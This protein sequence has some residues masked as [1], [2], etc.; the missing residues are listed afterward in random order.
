MNENNTKFALGFPYLR[1]LSPVTGE[2]LII[3]N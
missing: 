2:T 1:D 3:N